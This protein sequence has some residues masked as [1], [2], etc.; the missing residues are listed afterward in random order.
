M[1]INVKK[2]LDKN[3]ILLLKI[4]SADYSKDITDIVKQL[5]GSIGYVTLNKT[6]DSLKEEFKKK[7]IN[8]DNILFIDAISKTIKNAPEM[9][10]GSFFVSSP[11]ALT[12]LSLAIDRLLRHNFKYIIFDSLTNLMIYE[13]RAP[14]SKFISFITNKIRQ[15]KTK[16]VFYA[17]NIKEQDALIE[18]AGMFADKVEQ[19]K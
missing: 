17:L 8:T 19:I 5:D 15:T 12:E 9:A 10:E 18:E 11:A 13:K 1:K 4:P 2:E 14:V 6:F 3:Q 7:K 16:A